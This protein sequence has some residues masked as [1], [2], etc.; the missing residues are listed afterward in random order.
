MA[1]VTG[2]S[3]GIGKAIAIGL[4]KEGATVVVAA[5]TEQ[6]GRLPGTIHATAGEIAALGGRALPIRCDVRHEDC[7]NSMVGTTLEEWGRVDIL[8]NNAAIGTYTSFMETSVKLWDLVMAVDLRGPFLC[9]RA[10]LPAM[11]QQGR[12]SIVNISSL[13]ADRLLSSTVSKDRSDEGV[14][15]GQPY[16][17]AKAGLAAEVGGYNVAVNVVKPARPVV[18]EG[19]KLQRS[20]ADWSQWV[21]ADSMVKAAVFLARQD[22]SGVTGAVNTDEEFVRD[23][24]L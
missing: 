7:V 21:S 3:R 11:I 8:V 13:G 19:F 5:R 10:V 20:D 18:T 24:G 22:A 16:G 15:V 9:A 6:E 23:H 17:V 2:S 1:I 12:G 4:A 14:I